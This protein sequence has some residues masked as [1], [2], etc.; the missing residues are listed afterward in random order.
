MSRKNYFIMLEIDPQKHTTWEAIEPLLKEKRNLWSRPASP[1]KK[2]EYKANLAMYREIETLL[3]DDSARR[4]EAAEAIRELSEMKASAF[5]ELD[6]MILLVGA[7]EYLTTND[8]KHISA[9]TPGNFSAAEV[10]Q[11]AASHGL[12]IRADKVA[13]QRGPTL[14]ESTLNVMSQELKA[15]NVVDLYDFLGAPRSTSTKQLHK[16]SND[17]YNKTRTHTDKSSRGQMARNKLIEFCLSAFATQQARQKYDNSVAL[18][19]LL[20]IREFAETAGASEKQIVAS[21]M[22]KILAEGNRHG[23]SQEEV[24]DAVTEVAKKHGWPVQVPSVS[25]VQS[26]ATCGACG[27]LGQAKTHCEHCNAPREINCP[28]C[29]GKNPTG[30]KKCASC[31]F[32]VGD[33]H[34][35]ERALRSARALRNQDSQRASQLVDEALQFWPGNPQA[36]QLQAELKQIFAEE[37]QAAAAIELI[38]ERIGRQRRQREFEAAQRSLD[39]LIQK[40]PSHP[41]VSSFR[42]IISTALRQ[43]IS[44]VAKGDRL[45][46]SPETMDAAYDAYD[47]ALAVCADCQAARLGKKRCLPTPPG[48]LLATASMNSVDLRW[49]PSVSRGTIRYTIVRKLNSQPTRVDDGQ[50]VGNT[51][52]LKFQDTTTESG[53]RYF[54]S[55]FT[56][57]DNQ[58]SQQAATVGPIIRIAEVESLSTQVGDAEVTL[59]W[60]RPSGA[61]EIEVWRTL[62]TEPAKRGDGVRVS[63]S[64]DSAFD[65]D[66]K[67]GTPYGYRVVS[68]FEDADGARVA[69]AGVTCLVTPVKP[70][71]P[72]SDLRIELT[73]TAFRAHYTPP[74][75][76]LV[77]VFRTDS[78][79][80][81]E[82]GQTIPASEIPSL[83]EPL[84]SAGVNAVGEELMGRTELLLLPV[85]M[86][87]AAYV[88]G[89]SVSHKWVPAI[90]NVTAVYR[91]G[92]IIA[93]WQWPPG[94]NAA[95]VVVC[96]DHFAT[97]PDDES[98][99]RSGRVTAEQYHAVGGYLKIELPL[100][101]KF[102]LSI[103]AAVN[104]NDQWEHSPAWEYELQPR[105]NRVARY[106]ICEIGSLFGFISPT[107]YSVQMKVD[108]PTEL[109]AFLVV[110][111]P[112]GLPVHR[113]D[114]DV[115][116][117]TQPLDA[118]RNQ[119]IEIG[120]VEAP[121]WRLS[122][123]NTTLF[124]ANSEDG[125]WLELLRS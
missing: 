9:K 123:A 24:I 74:A 118:S 125:Q 87:G 55:V 92:A 103:F 106:E 88:A 31:Q 102:Y 94:T 100:S 30:A 58:Y 28:N 98:A 114:G 59:Q 115:L 101:A 68:V 53:A 67:N 108:G 110:S 104:R 69:S 15:A 37:R 23:L 65:N 11:R 38:A 7:K 13:P 54:Y 2:V 77:K 116:L 85:S 89:Q 61:I 112:E 70:P 21:V 109:P 124:H 12:S 99:I 120:R 83:G 63:C 3:K 90:E 39:E 64:G 43:A 4:A 20:S 96:S 42:S 18:L 117:T 84:K 95:F 80:T 82:L 46:S 105:E 17:E 56:Q 111:K 34:L 33:M 97:T 91:D 5:A 48:G 41:Q 75:H 119:S 72:V 71:E 122:R 113:G 1:A 57:R 27:S 8:L 78:P 26:L 47:A 45:S 107:E 22:D 6:R 19:R 25:S 73:N 51:T 40:A 36:L 50:R 29:S 14:D 121:A 10:Q 62:Q 93:K 60:K 79:S 86:V 35:A 76:G 49:Q 52:L 81:Y 16:L 44:H 32:E 66:L